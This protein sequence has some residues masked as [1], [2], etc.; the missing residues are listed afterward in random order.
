MLALAE[1]AQLNAPLLQGSRGRPV[2][3]VAMDLA[4]NLREAGRG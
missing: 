3:P 4:A 1:W 2:R